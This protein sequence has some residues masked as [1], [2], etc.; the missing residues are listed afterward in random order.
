M[1]A[2]EA[3]ARFGPEAGRAVTALLKVARSDAEAGV[4]ERAVLTLAAVDPEGGRIG[5]EL[6]GN[7]DREAFLTLLCAVGPEEKEVRVRLVNLW[8]DPGLKATEVNPGPD[9]AHSPD[10][11][12]VPWFGQTYT[13]S[14][15]QAACVKLLWENWESK[16]PE[17]GLHCIL[18]TAGVVAT[19]LTTCSGVTRRGARSSSRGARKGRTGSS[20]LFRVIPETAHQNTRLAHT[21]PERIPCIGAG[22]GPKG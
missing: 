7:T 14:P 13:F 11:R 9:A 22:S 17:V 6:G 8:E 3:L 15:N 21:P 20:R 19:R 12:S 10:F 4:R 5:R 2:C 18:E 1:S 16:T